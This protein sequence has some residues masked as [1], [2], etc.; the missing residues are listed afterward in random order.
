MGASPAQAQIRIDLGF[1]SWLRVRVR[2]PDAGI[3]A[4][5]PMGSN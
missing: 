4:L 3:I 5:S 2:R 1:G